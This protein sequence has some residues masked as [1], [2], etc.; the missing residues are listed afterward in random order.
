M[1]LGMSGRF[2]IETARASET[3]SPA[4]S[5]MRPARNGKH[6][7]RGVHHE[8]RRGDPLHRRAPVR[9][10]DA[11][12]GRAGSMRIRCS[13]A[14]ASSRWTVRS[15]PT[16]SPG[17]RP[18]G[19]AAESLPAG[20]ARDRRPRQHLCLRGTVPG[21]AVADR[22][23]SALATQIGSPRRRRPKRLAPAIRGGAEGRHRRRRL[24]PARLPPGRRVARLFPA[25]LRGLW[26]RRRALPAAKAAPALI[27][28]MVQ[29]GRS[30]FY[31]P[32][33]PEMSSRKPPMAYETI[34][35]EKRRPR[36]HHHPQPSRGAERPQ[37]RSSSPS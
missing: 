23:A 11:D 25:H 32:L 13:K 16:S 36:R 7:H 1:H 29:N 22:P 14:W 2:V 10:Y 28:R 27:A 9:L 24:V 34:L 19:A 12:R 26:P 3:T 17:A 20:S 31:C 35:V 21:A 5:S 37:R 15:R 18:G 30:T 33:L 4:S 6:D 8:Q